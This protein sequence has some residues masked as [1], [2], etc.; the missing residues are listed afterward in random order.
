MPRRRGTVVVSSAAKMGAAEATIFPSCRGEREWE[1]G[2]ARAGCAPFQVTSPY[3]PS[4]AVIII[5]PPTFLCALCRPWSYLSNV[6]YMT[7]RR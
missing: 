7:S 3:H 5:A 1:W 2:Q 4:E 6:V